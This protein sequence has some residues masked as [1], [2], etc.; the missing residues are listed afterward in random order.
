M[1]MTLITF[2]I[3]FLMAQCQLENSQEVSPETSKL[4]GKWRLAK[5]GYGFPAPNSPTEFT[6]TYE[7]ILEF[8]TSKG[9]F[10]RTKDGKVIESSSIK[11]SK[12]TDGGTSTRDAIVFEKDNTYSFFSFTENPVYLVL[13]ETVPIGAVLADGNSY[14]Y[15]KVK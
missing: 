3:T 15:E 12:L 8:N 9:T 14:F 2:I 11:S 13:Y 6:P 1:K 10:T 4:D 5:V 7:E